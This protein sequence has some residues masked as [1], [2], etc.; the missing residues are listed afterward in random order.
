MKA[1]RLLNAITFLMMF[2]G[3]HVFSAHPALAQTPATTFDELR[4][5]LSAG[6]RVVVTGAQQQTIKGRLEEL[7][8]SSLRLLVDKQSHD[9][10]LRDV[11]RVERRTRDSLVNGILIGAG[12]GGAF[13][14]KYYSENALCRGGCQFRSG[15]LGIVGIGAA[16][17]AGV[18]ALITRRETVFE[19]RASQPNHRNKSFA[20][21]QTSQTTFKPVED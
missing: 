18:D 16:A 19:R 12:I 8:P 1:R 10:A 15:A 2:A 3:C 11:L 21:G 5:R 13:F 14:L 20:I 4:S 6:D 7:S 9:V 17:G